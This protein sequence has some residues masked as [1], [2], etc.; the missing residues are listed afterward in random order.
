MNVQLSYQL[1]KYPNGRIA[2]QV[3]EMDEE[4]GCE[5]P[6]C[7]VTTNLPQESIKTK[8]EVFISMN[9]FNGLD[10]LKQVGIEYEVI[11]EAKSGF[12]IYPKVKLLNLNK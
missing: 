2:I 11:G 3:F 4:I 7:V 10:I 5:L 9:N 6:Y 8:D 12:C 1:R